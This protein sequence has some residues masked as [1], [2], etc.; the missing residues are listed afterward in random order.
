MKPQSAAGEEED[1]NISSGSDTGTESDEDEDTVSLSLIS[2]PG[3]T[4]TFF[5]PFA[6]F[7]REPESV[8][9]Y[10]QLIHEESHPRN[11]RN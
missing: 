7:N 2:S 9:V 10:D 4:F 8:V 6:G 5:L 3:S 1:E 11:R